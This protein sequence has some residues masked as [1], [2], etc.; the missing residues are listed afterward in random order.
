MYYYKYIKTKQNINLIIFKTI[1]HYI[2]TFVLLSYI[3]FLKILKISEIQFLV[4]RFGK[5]LG[6]GHV[7]ISLNNTVNKAAQSVERVLDAEVPNKKLQCKEEG[8]VLFND[9]LNTFYLRYMASDNI[10]RCTAWGRNGEHE[11]T[12]WWHDTVALTPVLMGVIG[13]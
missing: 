12:R 13:H 9:T 6:L 2:I 11:G 10:K 1:I 7:D 3:S 4:A 8:Y 5:L